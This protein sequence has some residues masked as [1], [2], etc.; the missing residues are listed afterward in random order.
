[1][2]EQRYEPSWAQSPSVAPWRMAQEGYLVR[3]TVDVC[4]TAYEPDGLDRLARRFRSGVPCPHPM[5]AAV[6]R[7][8]VAVIDI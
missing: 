1:V 5:R 7:L 6:Q 8:R 2:A 4:S 3:Q